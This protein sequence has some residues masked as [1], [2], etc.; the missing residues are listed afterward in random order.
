MF[1]IFLLITAL[2]WKNKTLVFDYVKKKKILAFSAIIELK[3]IR[4]GSRLHAS[5][6]SLFK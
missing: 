5:L 4:G 1:S 6:A 2:N 3:L